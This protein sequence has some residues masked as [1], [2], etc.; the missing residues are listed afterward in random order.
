VAHATPNRDEPGSRTSAASFAV[1]DANADVVD[2]KC[3]ALLEA[4][5]VA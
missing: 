4:Q 2:A 5:I 3:L 1:I